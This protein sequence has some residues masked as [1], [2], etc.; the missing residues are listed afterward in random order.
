VQRVSSLNAPQ[1]LQPTFSTPAIVVFVNAWEAS[2]AVEV[3][4]AAAWAR[5]RRIWPAT[6]RRHD[7]HL[8]DRLL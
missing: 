4:L 7:R 2:R 3:A 8:P 5:H 6:C 1:S